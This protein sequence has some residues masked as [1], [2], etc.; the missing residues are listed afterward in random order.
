MVAYF[1]VVVVETAAEEEA[2][3]E[4]FVEPTLRTREGTIHPVVV[5]EKLINKFDDV[6][7]SLLMMKRDSE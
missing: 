6:H 1:V 5:K 7:T 3:E 2:V 4:L